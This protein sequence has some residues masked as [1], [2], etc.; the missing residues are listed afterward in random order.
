MNKEN[1]AIARFPKNRTDIHKV[2]EKV[3]EWVAT[4]DLNRAKQ[5]ENTKGED[6]ILMLQI[7]TLNAISRALKYSGTDYGT[8]IRGVAQGL[9]WAAKTYQYF[10][11]KE[12]DSLSL[13]LN[14]GK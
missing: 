1:T 13:I 10:T 14:Y 12:I 9:L 5:A 6:R 11:E 2:Q 8:R 7:D 4:D 3:M